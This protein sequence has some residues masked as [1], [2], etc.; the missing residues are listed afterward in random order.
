MPDTDAI[1]RRLEGT[2]RNQLGGEWRADLGW[3]FLTQPRVEE[4][5]TDDFQMRHDVMHEEIVFR[6]VGVARNVGVRGNVGRWRGM[7][8]EI[9]INNGNTREPIHHEMGHFLLRVEE[10]GDAPLRQGT[11]IRQ[12]T[13]PRANAMMTLGMLHLGS[14]GAA[15]GGSS[16]GFYGARPESLRD[17]G[18][19]Q[20]IDVEFDAKNEMIQG[21]GGPDFTKPLAWLASKF[22]DSVASQ[23]DWVFGFR[24]ERPSQ[25]ASGQ[26]VEMPV[27]IGKLFSDFWLGRR[28]HEGA[29]VDVLQYA[30]RVDLRFHG[31]RWPHVS[32]NTLLKQ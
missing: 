10:N 21:K 31:V 29:D 5:G 32:L 2:W 12:A 26:R 24:D 30:Q 22:Q 11:V 1:F 14:V 15:A 8:Y 27:T 17:P 23:D 25:M 20:R 18:F 3:N 19:Q 9:R 16:R 6:H 28:K 13:I 7:A 4:P